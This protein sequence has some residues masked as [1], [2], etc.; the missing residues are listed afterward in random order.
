MDFGWA[1]YGFSLRRHIALRKGWREMRAIHGL[2]P[3]PKYILPTIIVDHN[4]YKGGADQ[5]T[6]EHSNISGIWENYLTPTQRLV[7]HTLKHTFGQ[8]FHLYRHAKIYE[9]VQ[10]GKITSYRQV[11]NLL[12]K[13]ISHKSFLAHSIE[14]MGNWMIVSGA[15]CEM[16]LPQSNTIGAGETESTAAMLTKNAIK[17][18]KKRYFQT[19]PELIRKRLAPTYTDPY[20]GQKG[21]RHEPQLLTGDERL[22]CGLCCKFCFTAGT[23]QKRP[24]VIDR[25]VYHRGKKGVAVTNDTGRMGHMADSLCSICKIPL[26]FKK[27]RFPNQAKSCWDI[28]HTQRDLWNGECHTLCHIKN[29]RTQ[30]GLD[31]T[32]KKTGVMNGTV[33][34]SN[35]K[36]RKDAAIVRYGGRV[37]SERS[38][39]V[40]ERTTKRRK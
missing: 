40:A 2:Q 8:P 11:R 5:K 10:R 23:L 37:V 31:C 7:V 14:T 26:C 39:S 1:G 18:N 24:E 30:L 9:D 33:D 21:M 25:K 19:V 20:A 16:S 3:S 27:L 6:R 29:P 35:M 32:Q 4:M 36:K 28:F 38:K 17:G 12:C 22:R 15:N 34:Y 13:V